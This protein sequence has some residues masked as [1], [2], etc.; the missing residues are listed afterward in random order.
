M[1]RANV[2]RRQTYNVLDGSV[3][4][5]SKN[6]HTNDEAQR[7]EGIQEILLLVA[8][9][10]VPGD[11][12]VH[13]GRE[14][15]AE[16]GDEESRADGQ[17]VRE[18]GNGLSNDPGND[19][20]A[21]VKSKPD[22]PA[23]WCVDI[24]NDVVG[25]DA[26]NQISAD[27]NRIDTARDEDD[28]ESDAES[29]LGESGTGR[30]QGGRLDRGANE[31]VDD[32]TS[33]R[34]D[35]DLDQAEG[36]NGLLVVCGGVHL[37]HETEL[38]HG[39]TVGENN[40]ADSDEGLGEAEVV[41][42][43]ARP[44]NG[45]EATLG[46]AR[47]NASSN[48]GDENGWADG[49]EIDVS[50]DGNLS[51]TG[52]NGQEEKKDSR[53]NTEDE[54]AGAVAVFRNGAPHDGAS[55]DV[56]ADDE[57]ELKDEHEADDFVANSAK[58]DTTNVG[59]V[60]NLGVL[61]L[62]LANNVSRVDADEAHRDR[63]NDARDHAESSERTGERQRTESDSLDDEDNGQTLPAETVELFLAI[64]GLGL[65]EGVAAQAVNLTDVFVACRLP[66]RHDGVGAVLLGLVRVHLGLCIGLV[67]GLCRQRLGSRFS[68]CGSE[69]WMERN[70][71]RKNFV[72]DWVGGAQV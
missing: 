52:R 50:E 14:V 16:A 7:V 47:A 39:E 4:A 63:E 29:D 44:G 1:Q 35:T 15:E 23:L 21:G 41:L 43:P 33:D 22:H 13:Q 58:Q 72:W 6:D 28:G 49:D 9:G 67:E 70:G 46:V 2:K 20:N 31:S 36:N 12:E 56:R 64:L 59:V 66:I 40:V 3:G 8:R 42:G 60:G 26:L 71:R 34:V 10:I 11:L 18:E 38:A 19:G 17:Q 54:R 68:S 37:V 48:H 27:D 69:G 61:Q 30:E 24:A 32:A 65:L 25:P 55:K 51:E 62:G 57:D 53:D 5:D 45:R